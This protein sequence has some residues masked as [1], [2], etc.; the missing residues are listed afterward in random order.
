M[1]YSQI[2]VSGRKII[3]GNKYFKV[4]N[5]LLKRDGRDF[6]KIAIEAEKRDLCGLCLLLQRGTS[7]R[8]DR[9]VKKQDMIENPLDVRVNLRVFG[10]VG[11][12][13][14]LDYATG[15]LENLVGGGRQ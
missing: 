7:G 1:L 2:H 8:L 5:C 14:E 12:L 4:G 11:I 13:L 6:L 9:T 3:I 10:V 15:Q